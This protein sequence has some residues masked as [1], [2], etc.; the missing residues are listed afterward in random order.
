MECIRDTNLHF[1]KRCRRDMSGITVARGKGT[2][3][4]GGS[5]VGGVDSK[6]GVRGDEDERDN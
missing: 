6:T 2:G 5:G 3:A 1:V 4:G